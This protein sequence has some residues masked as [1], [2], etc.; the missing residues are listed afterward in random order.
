[1]ANITYSIIVRS[2]DKLLIGK[3]FWKCIALPGILYASSVISWSKEELNNLQKIENGV[4]RQILGAPGYSPVVTLQGEIGASSVKAR[5]MKAKLNFVKYLYHAENKLINA[6]LCKLK[7]E[8]KPKLWIRQIS[9]YVKEVKLN[10]TL[11]EIKDKIQSWDSLRW[12]SELESKHSLEIYKSK[13][14]IGEEG[15][16][17]NSFSSVL[18]RCRT[19]TLKLNWRQRFV[20]GSVGCELCGAEEET[21]QHFLLFCTQ[22]CSIRDIYGIDGVIKL[23]DLL[24]FKRKDKDWVK[25]MKRYIVELWTVRKVMLEEVR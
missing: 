10:I 25:N 16:Y 12:R 15:I 23:V 2:C 8:N 5:D 18:F 20:G 21:L 22:F 6:I 13:R 9:E 17:C 24:L 11:K 4:W 14:E 3:T 7:E 1:M 19:N